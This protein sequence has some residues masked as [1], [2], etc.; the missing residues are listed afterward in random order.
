MNLRLPTFNYTK[1]LHDL[2]AGCYAWLQPDGSWGLSN[3]G[4][5]TDKTGVIE[6][7]TNDRAIIGASIGESVLIDTLY[8]FQ[9]TSEMLSAMKAQVPAAE[10]I[11]AVINTHSNGDHCNGNGLLTN[12]EIIASKNTAQGM[13]E[14]TPEMMLGYLKQAPSLGDFGVYFQRCFGQYQFQDVT[15]RLPT[16]TFE[17]KLEMRVGNRRLELIEVGPAHTTG[18]TI[19]HVPDAGVIYSGDILFIEGHPLIW[20]GPLENWLKACQLMLDLK[21]EIVVPGHGPITNAVGIK[22]VM[23][24]FQYV[25]E[26]SRQHFD[27]GRSVLE[28]AQAMVSKYSHWG[29]PERMIV[30]I[31]MMYSQFGGKTSR[32]NMAELFGLMA[33]FSKELQAVGNKK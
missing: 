21:P 5:V 14:E 31:A 28:A 23:D 18:D 27:A 19:V 6:L 4:L 11:K 1:G 3:A 32:P 9:L 12:V 17:G 33:N 2:G 15:R 16:K 20:A 25:A 24:Y 13:L 8:D 22:A 30:N 26:N 10:K 29:D 7:D